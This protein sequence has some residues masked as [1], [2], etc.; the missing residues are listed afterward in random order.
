MQIFHL[1][2]GQFIGEKKNQLDEERKGLDLIWG[3]ETKNEWIGVA[4][5]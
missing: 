4:V 5:V 2:I 1:G 3:L